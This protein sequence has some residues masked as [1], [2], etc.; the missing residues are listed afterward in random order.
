[1]VARDILSSMNPIYWEFWLG[2]LLV[3]TV[4]FARGGVMGGLTL[5][6]RRLIAGSP[7][8]SR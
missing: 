2:L 3:V 5:L 1:M 8:R 7:W 4:L 6:S